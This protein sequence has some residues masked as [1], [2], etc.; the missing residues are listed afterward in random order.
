[1]EEVLDGKN[2]GEEASIMEEGR[3]K[4]GEDCVHPGKVGNCFS[5]LLFTMD[6][7]R[8]FLRTQPDNWIG[9]DEISPLPNRMV[10]PTSCRR[11]CLF[12]C[13]T[14]PSSA[15]FLRSLPPSS[16]PPSYAADQLCPS[17]LSSRSSSPKPSFLMALVLLEILIYDA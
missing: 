14:S 16:A 8:Q 10:G 2:H 1:M 13:P 9:S 6:R 4:F 11:C 12:L 7:N 15:Y 5:Q 17:V 3:K